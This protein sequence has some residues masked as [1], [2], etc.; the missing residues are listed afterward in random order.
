MIDP[1]KIDRTVSLDTDAQILMVP[2]NALSHFARL[3]NQLGSDKS[4]FVTLKAN[5]IDGYYK[6]PDVRCFAVHLLLKA[7]RLTKNEPDLFVFY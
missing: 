6:S 7:G 3:T 5:A 2:S 1:F 4:V